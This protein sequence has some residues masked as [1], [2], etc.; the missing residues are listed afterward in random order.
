VVEVSRADADTA[1]RLVWQSLVGLIFGGGLVALA[2]R[3][4]DVQAV[5]V[6]ISQARPGPVVAAFLLV[7]ATTAAK[8]GRWHALFPPPERPSL[9]VLA[10]ALLAGQLVNAVLPLRA[11]EVARAVL[12]GDRAGPT[13]AAVL[14][15]VAAEKTFDVLLLLLASGIA[16]VGAPLPSWISLPLATLAVVGLLVF[17]VAVALPPGRFAAWA[18]ARAGFL[19]ARWRGLLSA[20]LRQGLGGLSALRSPWRAARA[21]GWSA[22]V[23]TLAAATN[24]VLFRAFDLSLPPGAAVW[25]LVLLH[26]GVLP[27]S[28]PARLGVFHALAIWGLAAFGIDRATGMAYGTL[29]HALVYGPQL[30]LGGMAVIW[31]WKRPNGTGL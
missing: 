7:L 31:V 20:A 15:T 12:A 25:L 8:V 9:L 14:G 19:P 26:V 24:G 13:A 29:L 5:W 30:I 18:D 6:A 22:L 27:P 1:R 3:G 21:V 2:A 4:I 17:L 16:A 11:G 10:R 23:W 28:S